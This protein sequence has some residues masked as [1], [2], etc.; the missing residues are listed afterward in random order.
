MND[1]HY[2][3]LNLSIEGHILIITGSVAPGKIKL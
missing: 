2:K 1:K 3:T